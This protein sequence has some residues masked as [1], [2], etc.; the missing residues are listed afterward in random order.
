MDEWLDGLDLLGLF[1]QRL[2]FWR[3]CIVAPA[4]SSL[5]ARGRLSC[6][7]SRSCPTRCLVVCAGRAFRVL[8]EYSGPG[9]YLALDAG[10]RLDGRA[11]AHGFSE[12]P[13][14]GTCAGYLVV[15][16]WD[17]GVCLVCRAWPSQAV[18][19][20]AP[21]RR[22]GRARCGRLMAGLAACLPFNVAGQ[23]LAELLGDFYE[24]TPN[25]LIGVVRNGELVETAAAG[26]VD[27]GFG[28]PLTD[29]SPVN[30][31]STAKQFTGMALALLHSR[32]ELWP[33]FRL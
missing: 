9:L 27:L 15:R 29:G 3:V 21:R 32:G 4:F 17:G 13:R 8:G 10:C 30:I 6:C 1:C 18:G 7:R 20:R 28:V 25:L 5:R 33:P 22:V 31:G 2:C 14:R 12:R 23:T 16:A 19:N 26:M 11:C 24:S